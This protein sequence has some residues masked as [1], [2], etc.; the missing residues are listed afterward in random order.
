MS[1]ARYKLSF[2]VP[3]N[4]HQ[5]LLSLNLRPPIKPNFNIYILKMNQGEIIRKSTF[6][7]AM[8]RLE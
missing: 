5:K 1:A 2:Y 3:L 7:L 4:N 6:M 8:V